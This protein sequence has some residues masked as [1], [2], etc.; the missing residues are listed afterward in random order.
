V[1]LLIGVNDQFRGNSV[2]EYRPRFVSLLAQAIDFAGG[3]LGRVVVL[4]IPDWSVTPFANGRRTA[5]TAAEIDA[6]NAANR[7]E[8][9]E[10]EVHYVDVTAISRLAAQE[11]GLLASDGLHP[12][13]EM[14][15]LWVAEL[16]PKALEILGQ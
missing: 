8:A 13:A 12:S 14:Y 2:E 9:Q 10:A 5:E 1:T 3:D 7:E 6:F 15:A 16:L 4:S 11:P